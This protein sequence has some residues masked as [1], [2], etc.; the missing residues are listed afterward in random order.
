MAVSL[1]AMAQQMHPSEVAVNGYAERWV[2]PDKFVVTIVIAE[3]DSK[4]K[5]SVEEQE[6]SLISALRQAGVDVDKALRLSDSYSNYN[7]RG[8]LSTKRYKLT[9]YG[10][11]A[12]ATAFA[13]LDELNL[14]SVELTD[15]ICTKLKAVREQLR[16]EAMRN[17]RD[18]AKALA[19]A[20]DQKIGSCTYIQDSQYGDGGVALPMVANKAKHAVAES[21]RDE[22]VKS[23]TTIEFRSS[24]ITH[25]VSAMFELLP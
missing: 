2:S 18:R 7:R 13:T 3:K 20:V 16:I 14:S 11:E 17:A 21:A 1:G 15:A 23:V 12:L 4:G 25:S 6:R 24:K 5:I 19:E 10:N 22:S 9:L 8:S